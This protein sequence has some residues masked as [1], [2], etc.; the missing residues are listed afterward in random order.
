MTS[1]RQG[2]L[3]LGLCA[4][5][6]L[7]AL[8]RV[9][10]SSQNGQANGNSYL[11]ANSADGRYIAFD[12]DASNLVA[13]D[14]NGVRDVFIR[15]RVSGMLERVS[16]SSSGTQ[17]LHI[18][19]AAG[20]SADGR[21]VS[22]QSRGALAP[23]ASDGVYQIYRRD[24]VR[25]VTQLV[26]AGSGGVAGNAN[27]MR[28]S[29]SA[30]GRYILFYSSA[31]N[32]AA[33]DSN[34]VRDV[35]LKDMQ[36]GTVERISVSS[37]GVAGNGESFEAAMSPDARFV[38][39]TSMSTNLTG[40]T[41]AKQRHI[42]LRDRQTGN[43]RIISKT[44]SG[45][46]ANQTTFSPAL[47]DD[48]RYVVYYSKANNLA[49]GT[50]GASLQ[51]LFFDGNSGNTTLLSRGIS[52]SEGNDLSYSP[53]I[54]ADG[55]FVSFTS[56]AN[57]LI[58]GDS[59]G[60]A[61]IVLLDRQKN[62][63]QI[64]TQSEAGVLGNGTAIGTPA[65]SRDG[66]SIAF[67][68]YASNLL[69]G[70]SNNVS[71][72]F[73]RNLNTNTVPIASAGADQHLQCSG[74][75]SN[76]TLDGRA[77][78]DADGDE[79]SYA[80]SVAGGQYTGAAITV[81]MALG[82]HLATLNVDDQRGGVNSDTLTINISDTVAPNLVLATE[83]LLEAGSRAGSD[84]DLNPVASDLC[85]GV[86]LTISPSM[87][88]YP[89]GETLVS[90]SASDSS[91]NTTEASQR[92]RVED[93]I[94]PILTVPADIRREADARQTVI[95]IGAATATDIF[96]V[97][98]DNDAPASFGVGSTTINW[99]ATDSNSNSTTG[100]QIVTVEDTTAPV[101]GAINAIT[102]EATAVRTPLQLSAPLVTDIFSVNL[103]SN[104]PADYALGNTMVNWR[105]EDIHGNVSTADQLVT[106]QDT[107]A[108]VINIPADMVIEASGVLT[109][110]QPGTASVE[111]IFPVSIQNDAAAS[112]PLGQHSV[113]WTAT[114]SSGNKS[115]ATQRIT[116][117]D[118]TAP[119][120]EVVSEI[121]V[122]AQGVFTPVILPAVNSMDLFT[123]T[124]SNNAPALFPLG[125]TIVTWVAVDING[126]QT[127]A[128]QV[129]RVVDTTAP[130]AEITQL[131]DEIWP[132]NNKMVKVARVRDLKDLVDAQPQ[133]TALVEW[134]HAS[135]SKH[136]QRATKQKTAHRTVKHG[137]HDRRGGGTSSNSRDKKLKHDKKSH[138]ED[139]RSSMHDKKSDWKLV[140]K[141][142][143]WYLYVRASMDGR[144]HVRSYNITITLSDNA[145]NQSLHTMLV[146]VEHKHQHEGKRHSDE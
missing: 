58:S 48:G 52:G 7:Q 19:A 24:R 109:P 34:G 88:I 41:I 138:H 73:V 37:S 32:L 65:L 28:S 16:I 124:V 17:A 29:I 1:I 61:D 115:Q 135:D 101:Y 111:D 85:S 89:L 39:F 77:S 27:S 145:G 118:T 122:E 140:Q 31:N 35:F 91:G 96:D 84:Y 128:T 146:S 143:E 12:S 33:G 104:A 141:G 54:S 113:T 15:D 97:T 70:D 144:K 4:A 60:V 100:R 55:R 74:V 99:Q 6:P 72:I 71:D 103:S 10:V 92:I 80:W 50:T 64:I 106:I 9:S 95:D 120:L 14:T 30:N 137:D 131:R 76:V 132:P 53:S 66:N 43:T 86:S 23:G 56:F 8:E 38:A 127:Q 79:L 112:L 123:L 116:L 93:S 75:D 25:G 11:V 133:L 98:I 5:M 102:Q 18:S 107:T 94:A 129:V 51:I 130:S 108:P 47:S 142:D 26:S 42:Y 82:R 49:A 45:V 2:L 20:V 62:E 105:A 119:I 125:S 22:F 110:V 13:G 83:K 57:N 69:S 44:A 46:L 59:N 139:R 68:T 36:T 87:N 78:S 3:L 117:Q 126:N 136:H 121:V 67:S 81:P 90:V 40:S 63:M 134:E 21:Y 114:D